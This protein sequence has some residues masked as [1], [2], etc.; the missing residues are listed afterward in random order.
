MTGGPHL[1]GWQ[2]TPYLHTDEYKTKHNS[3]V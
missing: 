1:H 2:L 3:N